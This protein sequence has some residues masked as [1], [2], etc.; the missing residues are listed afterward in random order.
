MKITPGN[1]LEH[2]LIGLKIRV[3]ESSN[4]SLQGLEGRVIDETRNMLVIEDGER[5]EKK[6]PKAGNH[7]IFELDGGVR[8]R[9]NGEK[10]I[11]RPEDRIKR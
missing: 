8:V 2:E 7:F 5:K 6:I 10:L 11:S 4:S 1:L 9:V 3:D